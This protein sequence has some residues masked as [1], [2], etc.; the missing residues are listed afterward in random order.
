MAKQEDE[1]DMPPLEYVGASTP[2]EVPLR[3]GDRVELKGLSKQE[4]NGQKGTLQS[5]AQAAQGRLAVKLDSGQRVSIKPENLAKLD[6]QINGHAPAAQQAADDADM[7]P[8][9]YVGGTVPNGT[10]DADD[11]DMPPLEYLGNVPAAS[12]KG[13]VAKQED[14]DDM[15]PLEYVGAS[16]PLEVPLREGDRVELKGLS[17]NE[18]NG[19]KG[20]LQSFAQAAQGRLAVKL[21]SGQRVSIKPENLAKLDP[22]INGH[23]PAAQQAADDADMPPLEYVGG[24]VPNGTGDADDDDMPPL[25][26]LGNVPA[27]SS[28]GPVA[29]Q[30]DEDDMPPLEYV[31]ASTPLE[32]PLRE[33]D[34]V[35]LKGLSKNE[36]NGQ[37]GTL[38]SFAQAAQGRLA[39]KLDSGQR[40]SIKPENLAKL[41]PQINGH[42]PAAQQAADDADMPP[43]EYVGGTV[44]NGTGDADDDDMP[45]LEYL[46]NVPAASSK[47][48]VAK[49]EDEDDMPPLEYVGASTPLEVPLREGD[50]VELKG[51]SKKELNGQKGTLQSFAQAAQGRL[52]VKLDSGQ[53]VSIKP[54]NLAKL[55]PQING[56]APAAQQA[57]D[58]ADMPPLEYVGGT[59]PNGTGDAD[60]DDMPPLEYLGNVPAASSKGP[61][62]KQEDEDDMPPLE[63]VGASAPLEV[64]LC[65][66]DRVELKGLSKKELNGQKGT[67]QSFAQ[68]AQGRLAVKL[69]SGQRV[70]IKLEN[71]AKLDPQINGH[72]P[73]AQQAADDA[74]MPPLEY[75]GGTVPNGTA[76]HQPAKLANRGLQAPIR[77]AEQDAEDDMPP[78]EYVG[79]DLSAGVSLL[80]GDRVMLKGLCKAGLDGQTGKLQSFE[81]A[82][83]GR[84]PVKLDS[85]QLLAVKPINLE[86]LA[87]AGVE[88]SVP[89]MPSTTQKVPADSRAAKV[90]EP[91]AEPK[92]TEGIPAESRSRQ[93]AKI[94]EDISIDLPLEWFWH[95]GVGESSTHR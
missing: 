91:V 49:Q 22:Q 74:D 60:D 11:D 82:T 10:G 92:T 57:A 94:P 73:A 19:Q 24:T 55:D 41:D 62:A 86:K 89:A 35:E 21:D 9:E 66:G 51:L 4:L 54:E 90:D 42:A 28:K 40:V 13:P 63:Y 88:R 8:L 38:Q 44:P 84:L 77:Q 78:L 83:K 5:F 25:E 72:A 46:G 20:T 36:L 87:S 69:D 31:G 33:G 39:V 75:V 16:T 71:L 3:E 2:L 32:V 80:E 1:D 48:P 12:S 76:G 18:L 81:R 29:K 6:P 34:R 67:L 85:G 45:P 59:V 65:E 47:G 43:L 61:V 15:P 52:A 50:R 58:D 7:P 26:Y 53:R 37:K 64:P 79:Q 56:H 17:K 70:S 93:T 95:Q 23:A 27:A 14:E 30:E 68:A